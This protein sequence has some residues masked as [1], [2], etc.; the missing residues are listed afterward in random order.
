MEDKDYKRLVLDHER[1][2]PIILDKVETTNSKLDE[3]ISVLGTQNIIM[4]RMSN[5]DA[6]MHEFAQ[7]TRDEISH[8]KHQQTDLGCPALHVVQASVHVIEADVG[9]L[10]RSIR[11]FVGATTL[12]W[13]IGLFVAYSVTY[14]VFMQQENAELY[15]HIHRL[16]KLVTQQRQI[17]MYQKG[18]NARI[19]ER[20]KNLYGE[21]HE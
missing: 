11:E 17:N 8:V 13:A 16:D 6:N 7:R 3:V 9:I 4:E 10:R 15:S 5:M 1:D 2:I 19:E 18:A 20:V 12:R 14:A 21:H